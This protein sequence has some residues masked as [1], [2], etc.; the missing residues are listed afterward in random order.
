MSDLPSEAVLGDPQYRYLTIQCQSHLNKRVAQQEEENKSNSLEIS[1][2]FKLHEQPFYTFQDL[3]A[4]LLG[5]KK[6]GVILY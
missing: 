2:M 3:L 6:G 5:E 4:L 1:Q